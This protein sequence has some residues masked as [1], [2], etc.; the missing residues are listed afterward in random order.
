MGL[1]AQL[2]L[3]ERVAVRPGRVGAVAQL[4]MVGGARLAGKPQRDGEQGPASQDF[5]FRPE[6]ADVCADGGSPS[7]P[8][9]GT[10][11]GTAASLRAS[12]AR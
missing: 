9:A 1:Q 2:V 5:L 6:R 7:P 11:T 3:G 4:F 10:A 12:M 8:E